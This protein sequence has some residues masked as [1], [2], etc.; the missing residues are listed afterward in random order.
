MLVV[1]F[2]RRDVL[3]VVVA[4]AE[5]SEV[6]AGAA[7]GAASSV[8]DRRCPADLVELALL[9][10]ATST[11]R[12]RRAALSL[13]LPPPGR[14]RARRWWAERDRRAALDGE[15]LTDRQ[16]ALLERAARAPPAR[17]LAGAAAARGARAGARSSAARVRRAPPSTPPSA[18][19]ARGSS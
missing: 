11:A 5:E 13:V 14:A 2:G 1:P 4:L 8:L 7:R 3:G 18:R 16:R 12:R 15:R 19:G 6:A 9:D 17:D 10:R